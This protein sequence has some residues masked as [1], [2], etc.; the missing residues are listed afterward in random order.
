MAIKAVKLLSTGCRKR[1]GIAIF[2]FLLEFIPHE[3]VLSG[4]EGMRGGNDIY[5]GGYK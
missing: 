5:K 4:A 2:G 3:P 1:S